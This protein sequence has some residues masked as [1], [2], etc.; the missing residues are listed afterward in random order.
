MRIHSHSDLLL[1]VF[2]STVLINLRKLIIWWNVRELR[3][4]RNVRQRRIARVNSMNLTGLAIRL[5]VFWLL[6]VLNNPIISRWNIIK[7]VIFVIIESLLWYVVIFFILRCY[8]YLFFTHHVSVTRVSFFDH[9]CFTMLVFIL[10]VF[11]TS[12]LLWWTARH[13]TVIYFLF[14]WQNL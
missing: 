9:R 12:F 7:I 2:L 11:E 14:N 5:W 1:L 13:V 4:W 10:D 8:M 6:W 3:L